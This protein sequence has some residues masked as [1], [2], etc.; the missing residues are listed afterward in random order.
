MAVVFVSIG[1][2]IDKQTNI[3]SCIRSLK[4][5]FTNLQ[6]SSVYLSKAFG[7]EGDDFY[8]MV[9]SFQTTLSPQAVAQTLNDIERQHGRI[10]GEDSFVSRELD[11]DQ[12]LY[13]DLVC[14]ENSV[15]LPCAEIT[16]HPFVLVPLSEIAPEGIHP[17]LGKS[18]ADLLAQ[19]PEWSEQVERLDLDLA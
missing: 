9:A 3:Q 12:M 6:C 1:S 15:C 10:K 17:V 5:H 11:L 8:N 18:Y 14:D 4:K 19:H 13:D 7:F 2:N 16:E